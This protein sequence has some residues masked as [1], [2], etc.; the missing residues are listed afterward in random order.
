MTCE[1]VQHLL[2]AGPDAALP[3]AVRDHLATCP[4]CRKEA[5]RLARLDQA[6]IDYVAAAP[7]GSLTAT[8]Q[9]LGTPHL[10]RR[11][12]LRRA[13]AMLG[14]GLRAFAM[15]SAAAVAIVMLFISIGLGLGFA[16]ARTLVHL[17]LRPF[18]LSEPTLPVF[19]GV[20][21]RIWI[22][23]IAPADTPPLAVPTRFEVHIG[24][25]LTSAPDALIS[26]RLAPADGGAVRYFTPPVRILAG[27]N[28]VIVRFTLD[29]ARARDLLHLNDVQLEVLMRAATD[30]AT[31]L[32]RLTTGRWRIGE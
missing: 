30:E 25:T 3:P 8:Q 20:G 32:D 4:A 5:Q 29:A 13:T 15:R 1:R 6:L 16:Q 26:V 9:R 17:G 28:R 14:S 18:G 11:V 23:R 24:Y 31:I 27:T 22:E 12:R 21:D 19:P 7:L 10:R 2:L